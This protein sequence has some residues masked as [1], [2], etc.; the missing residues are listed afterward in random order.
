MRLGRLGARRHRAGRLG[1]AA[2]LAGA[3][4]A[5]VGAIKRRNGNHAE[6]EPAAAGISED[7]IGKLERLGK[8]RKAGVLSDEEF[9]AEKAD[10]LGR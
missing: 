1:K 5:V 4:T 10:I 3:A 6:E 2:V 9:E 8:L 7:Q